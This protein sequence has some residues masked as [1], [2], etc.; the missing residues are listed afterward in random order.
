MPTAVDMAVKSADEDVDYDDDDS[1]ET[2]RF[3][4]ELC[5]S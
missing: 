5:C 3:M 1:R 2:L 4:S